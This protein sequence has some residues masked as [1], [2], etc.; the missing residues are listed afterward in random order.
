MNKFWTVSPNNQTNGYRGFWIS[1][2]VKPRIQF[3]PYQF[4]SSKEII[5]EIEF[6]L[7]IGCP[8]SSIE[9]FVSFFCFFFVFFA[10][11]N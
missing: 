4:D 8:D 7:L 10:S 3:A 5:I 2:N 6:E 11:L 1:D 9:I